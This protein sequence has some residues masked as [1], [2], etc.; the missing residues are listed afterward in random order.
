VPPKMLYLCD[1][2]GYESKHG[3]GRIVRVC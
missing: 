1:I 3:V 2:A